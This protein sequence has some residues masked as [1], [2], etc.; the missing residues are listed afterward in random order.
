MGQVPYPTIGEQ[1]GITR[2]IEDTF[3]A[4]L[5][6]RPLTGFQLFAGRETRVAHWGL[7][8]H[9][10]FERERLN[11]E[12][13]V[14][15]EF[16]EHRGGEGGRLESHRV[17][18][19]LLYQDLEF[20]G[21]KWRQ[22]Q[23]M[24]LDP[25]AIQDV[26]EE[27][28]DDMNEAILTGF[29]ANRPGPNTGLLNWNDTNGTRETVTAGDWL[30]GDADVINDDLNEAIENLMNDTSNAGNAFDATELAVLVS[31]ADRR[32]YGRYAELPGAGPR[33]AEK[34][35]DVV[36][37]ETGTTPV[38]ASTNVVA[39]GEV[40]VI[41]LTPGNFDLIVP[42]NEGPFRF[43]LGEVTTGQV[44]APTFQVDDEMFHSRQFRFVNALT[45]RVR[46]PDCVV[47]ISDITT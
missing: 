6:F 34:I 22:I 13:V 33:P 31:A 40:Y 45:P 11:T 39:S 16:G 14:A 7:Q 12:T 3:L 1:E 20:S 8:E 47:Q 42:Q 35:R 29:P 30:T 36:E 43:G 24:G 26:A 18:I 23:E 27:M 46:R 25:A 32:I 5:Q 28:A 37:D 17:E 15:H 9:Q 10:W 41:D 44:S 4:S 38:V 2:S 21:R 19:P